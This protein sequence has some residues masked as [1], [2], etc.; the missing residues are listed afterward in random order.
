VKGQTFERLGIYVPAQKALGSTAT[1]LFTLAMNVGLPWI[2]VAG[3]AGPSSLLLWLLAL[4][5]FFVPLA[6]ASVE[7][8]SRFEGEGGI[9][10]WVRGTFGEFAGFMC[11]WIYW[12]S[13]FSFF[14]TT[15]YSI[16]TSV[17]L[18]SGA[19]KGE[20]PLSPMMVMFSSIGVA[21]A[22]L[23]LQLRGLGIGKWIT[24]AGGAAIL[25]LLALIIV[26]GVYFAGGSATNF[27]RA[28][29]V[30][31]ASADTAILWATMVFAYCGVEGLAFMRGDI[32]DGMR[33]I[34]R[35][36]IMLGIALAA[37]YI[38][39]TIAVLIIVP[40]DE[41]TRVTGL[42]QALQVG[43]DRFGVP[44]LGPVMISIAAL[45]MLGSYGAW[46]RVSASLPF[47]AG[48]AHYL[49]E[50]FGRRDARTGAPT[51]PLILQAVVVV[52]LVVLSQAGASVR[53]A[54]DFLI[55]ITVLP[56]ALAY[57]FLFATYFRAQDRAPPAGAYVSPGGARTA[58]V[59]AATGFVATF[60]TVICSV[61]PSPSESDKTLAIAK[62]V[63]GA[64]L[65]VA[66]GVAV[67]VLGRRRAEAVRA[68]AT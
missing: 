26:G 8:T 33:A 50:A 68:R 29:Y 9:Y 5:L 7:L 44:S 63:I 15:L 51:Y 48:V 3:V 13:N 46:F 55:S 14:A 22:V 41:L 37:V 21:L 18:A 24:N 49:P 39:G 60:V 35:A 65:L 20:E 67:Y 40:A 58:R 17:A 1:L 30:P 32:R 11:G 12:T 2:A 31:P 53:A 19:G 45:A 10:D 38:L 23:A 54:Y 57:L 59:I 42:P 36:T 28:S 4:V 6:V 34:L 52:A 43:A 16:V 61:V 25:A 66:S 62:L 27:R 47:V 64:L 56:I